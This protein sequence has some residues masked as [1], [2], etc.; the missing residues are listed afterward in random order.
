MVNHIRTL[1]LNETGTN[2]PGYS[3]PLEEYVPS[4]YKVI[5]PNDACRR[6]LIAL[7]GVYPD[8]AYKNWRL[9]QIS[10]IAEAC[11][12]DKYWYKFDGRVT[13]FGRTDTEID[14]NFGKVV[15]GSNYLNDAKT[16][17]YY[18]SNGGVSVSKDL[19]SVSQTASEE[20]IGAFV[21]GYPSSDESRGRVLSYWQIES[22]TGGTLSVK[23]LSD[24]AYE[25]NITLSFSGGLSDAVVLRGSGLQIKFRNHTNS[26][27]DLTVVGRP[28]TDIGVV[29]ANIDAMGSEVPD[30]L[31]S[32]S[33]SEVKELKRYWDSSV[34][35]NERLSAFVIALGYRL[36]EKR[37]A[38]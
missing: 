23:R 2:K 11:G 28:T 29:M 34:D 3:F 30:Y 24:P 16:L 20:E 37:A 19:S 25:D 32:S 5:I 1:L 15:I 26:S 13:H 31:F 33:Y 14:N 21:S 36:E 35:A 22:G 38:S 12:F 17:T 18:S 9:Y 4:D 8:R 7:F 6:A 10:K 27:W